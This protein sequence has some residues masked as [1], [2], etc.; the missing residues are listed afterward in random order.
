MPHKPPSCANVSVGGD[1]QG[2]T[3]TIF[4]MIEPVRMVFTANVH[5]PQ[6][7]LTSRAIVT[8]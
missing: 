2:A 4:A 3:Y 7:A 1:K 8:M 5:H 6:A